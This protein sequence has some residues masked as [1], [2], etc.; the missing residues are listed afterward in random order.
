MAK[1]VNS[2]EEDAALNY[3]AA[4][5]KMCICSQQPTTYAQAITDYMLA[6]V[7]LVAGAG[8]GDFTLAADSSG[9]K[10]T[11]TAKSAVPITNNGTATHVALVSTGDSTLR[12][13]TT[14]TSQV[15]TAG[16]TV[17]IPAFKFNIQD[18]T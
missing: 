15:L 10:V 1:F 6:N 8:N 4:S 11:V 14:C 3:I 12:A 17:D 9:R 18:P 16:G 7:V 2:A 5:T 13:G